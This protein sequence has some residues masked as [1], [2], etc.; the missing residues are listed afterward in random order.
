MARRE[1]HVGDPAPWFIAR[2]GDDSHFDFD[3]VAGRYV[4][5]SFLGSAASEKIAAVVRHVAG[6]LRSRFDDN[7]MI[8]FGVSIDRGDE[9]IRLRDLLPGVRFFWDFDLRVSKLYGAVDDE[10][11]MS[12]GG[13]AYRPVTLVLDPL[14][15]VLATIPINDAATHNAV[16]AAVLD[17]LPPIGLH[18]GAPAP[19]LVLPRVFEP[20]FCR[21]LIALYERHG[22]K[23][24]GFMEQHDGLTVTV[25]DARS[26]RRSDFNFEIAAEFAPLRMAIRARLVRR[27]VPEIAKAFQF[28]VTH[29]ERYIV[30]C[31]ESERRGFFMA[32]RDNTTVA[33]AHRKFAC[34]LNLNAEDYDGGELR[35]PEFGP[36]TYKAPTGGAVVFS[37]SLL[38]EAL[39]VT[40]GT[41]FVF[42]PFL[43]DEP[44]ARQRAE[45]R[46]Y[47]VDATGPVEDPVAGP[48]LPQ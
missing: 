30:A 3:G 13:V 21:E 35:F 7:G 47:I 15:R 44:A 16:L 28:Q 46:K 23:E 22:G 38:H 31:Y 29:I 14:L 6:P 25:M 42:L 33:T 36:Q 17:A 45:N 37:C 41:R 40:R 12:G 1:F 48:C 11:T 26:K 19:V 10:A 39:P 20:A 34:T 27:L 18:A 8:F 24:S 4:V 9:T 32:H 43:Y 5:L 2:S